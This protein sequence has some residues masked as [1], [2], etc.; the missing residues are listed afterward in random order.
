M[1]LS[2]LLVWAGSIAS[3]WAG[4]IPPPSPILDGWAIAIDG[5]IFTSFL[6][7]DTATQA[8]LM[9]TGTVAGADVFV[10]GTFDAGIID[11]I[12]GNGQ[13]GGGR[14][15]GEIEVSLLGTGTHTVSLW[16]DHHIEL[17]PGSPDGPRFYD[18]YGTVFGSLPSDYNFTIDEP[19]YGFNDYVGTAYALNAATA[20]DNI[21][22]LP[23][24]GP[25]SPN[26][27]SMAISITKTIDTANDRPGAKWRFDLNYFG[28]GYSQPGAFTPTGFYLTQQSTLD[29]GGD[30]LYFSAA[31]EDIPEPA[32]WYMVIGGVLLLV[33]LRAR[34]AAANR[35]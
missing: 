14:G 18:E 19:G 6:N 26:D 12:G 3:V 24:G 5:N 31:V 23:L 11:N 9:T 4:T 34:R 28:S 22:H 15:L 8:D 29:N 2:L 33:A 35:V 30:T 21:N 16:V 17:D 13:I 20:L 10:T 1:F 27:V 25:N 32:A 7:V